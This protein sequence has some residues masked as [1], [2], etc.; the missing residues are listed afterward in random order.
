MGKENELTEEEIRELEEE[1]LA[2]LCESFMYLE[3]ITDQEDPQ[4]ESKE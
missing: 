2:D 1:A 4:E 3:S